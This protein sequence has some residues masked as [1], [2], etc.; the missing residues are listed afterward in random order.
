MRH[1]KSSATT[2]TYHDYVPLSLKFGGHCSHKEGFLHRAHP[3]GVGVGG[4]FFCWSEKH[5]RKFC[6]RGVTRSGPPLVVNMEL[7]TPRVITPVNH[8]EGHF[9]H[10]AGVVGLG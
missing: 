6:S 8:L 5:P 1:G 3:G 7:L 10:L 2:T 9:T 4:E